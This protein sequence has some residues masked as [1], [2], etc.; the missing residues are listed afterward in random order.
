VQECPFEVTPEHPTDW[1]LL[2]LSTVALV[3]APQSADVAQQ[4]MLGVQ[5][6]LPA[7][8]Q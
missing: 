2:Q 6:M 7:A 8:V 1:G 5:T 4:F 3:I